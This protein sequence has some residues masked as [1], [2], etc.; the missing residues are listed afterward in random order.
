MR[1]LALILLAV[2][3]SGCAMSRKTDTKMAIF[4]GCDLFNEPRAST[5]PVLPESGRMPNDGHI[6]VEKTSKEKP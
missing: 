3:L 1:T 2:V 4:C 5:Q 6:G